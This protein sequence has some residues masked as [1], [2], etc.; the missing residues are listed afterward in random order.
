MGTK[1]LKHRPGSLC[2][3]AKLAAGTRQI[4]SC[5]IMHAQLEKNE[6]IRGGKGAVKPAC[7]LSPRTQCTKAQPAQRHDQAVGAPGGRGE[8]MGKP[9]TVSRPGSSASA[10]RTPESNHHCT[11]ADRSPRTPNSRSQKQTRACATDGWVVPS[12]PGVPCFMNSVLFG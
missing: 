5:P 10:S 8:H 1:K 11:S 3:D 2:N 7:P 4:G 6:G 12:F 9:A